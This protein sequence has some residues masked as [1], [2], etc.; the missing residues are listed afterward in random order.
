MCHNAKITTQRRVALKPCL[1]IK[2]SWPDISA[3]NSHRNC[4][5][6]ENRISVQIGMSPNYG[7]CIL[8]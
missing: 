6:L 3:R 8:E 5:V 2:I 4:F 7:S 1:H